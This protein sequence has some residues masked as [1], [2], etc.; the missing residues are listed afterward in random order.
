MILP[1]FPYRAADAG[2][3]IRHAFVELENVVQRV[4]YLARN[5][6]PVNRQPNREVAIPE[7]D[8]DFQQLFGIERVCYHIH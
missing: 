4:R 6:G 8:Q 3:L 2:K 5:S 1:L 7:G